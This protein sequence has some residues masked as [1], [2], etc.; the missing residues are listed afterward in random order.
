MPVTDEQLDAFLQNNPALEPVQKKAVKQSERLP[1]V[2]NNPFSLKWIP[3]VTTQELLRKDVWDDG[4]IEVARKGLN[5]AMGVN[6]LKPIS[7]FDSQRRLN[8]WWKDTGQFIPRDVLD[9]LGVQGG[10]TFEAF[11]DLE[12]VREG[13]ETDNRAR[14]SAVKDFLGIETDVSGDPLADLVTLPEVVD[15]DDFTP[16]PEVEP[17]M[18]DR[19]K[20]TDIEDLRFINETINKSPGS[21]DPSLAK[22]IDDEI[23]IKETIPE[24]MDAVADFPLLS[25]IGTDFFNSLA[26][27]L[28]EFTSRKGL[29]PTEALLGRPKGSESILIRSMARIREQ[30]VAQDPTLLA[31]IG[32][33]SGNILA[34]IIQFAALPD[35]SKAKIFAKLPKVVK[36]AIGV[37][38]KAGLIEA[39]QAPGSGDTF[40]TRAKEIVTATGIGALTGVALEVFMGSARALFK[41]IKDLPVNKQADK[42]LFNNPDTPFT[43]KEI[44]SLLKH[45]KSTDP[46]QFKTAIDFKPRKE[47]VATVRPTRPLLEKRLRPGF[48]EIEKPGKIIGKVAKQVPKT[49]EAIAIEAAKKILEVKKVAA[50]VLPPKLV[51]PE[52]A[53]PMKITFKEAEGVRGTKIVADPTLRRQLQT[54][55]NEIAQLK[56][57]RDELKA[58]KQFVK[59]TSKALEIAKKE[60]ALEALREKSAIKLEQTIEGS[61]AKISKIREAVEFKESLRNDAVSMVTA[62]PRE[63][64]A[65]FINRANK[66]KTIKALNK[67]TDE[68][69]T[70][71][72]KFERKIAVGDLRQTI[73]KIESS[74]KLG[75][76]RLAKLPSP[77]REKIMGI[78]D[79]IS[80]KK[81][82]KKPLPEGP[83]TFG[84]LDVQ[85]KRGREQ[86]LGADLESLQQVTQKLSTELAGGLEAL[87]DEAELAL[88]LPD[89]RVRRLNVL[90]QKNISE[91]DTEDIKLVTQSLQQLAQNAKL[92]TQLL[93]KKGFKPIDS[94]LKTITTQE[95]ATIG[96]ARKAAAKDRPVKVKKGKLEKVG[97]FNKK[98]LKL[99]DAHLDTLVQLS[100]NP[101]SK[102]LKQILDTDLHEGL[103]DTA[104]KT[105]EWIDLSREQFD[106]IGFKEIKQISDEVEVILAGQKIKLEK[107]FLVKLELHSRSPENLKAILKTK[108]WV[109]EGK[110]FDYPKNPDG[111]DKIN[112][113]AEIKQALNVVRGSDTLTGIADWTN[114]LTPLRADAINEVS[115]TLNGFE[116]A[117]DPFYTSRPRQLPKRVEGGKDISVPPEQQGQYLP[118]TGGTRRMRLDRWSDDFLSGIESDAFLSGMTMPLRNARV[119]VSSDSFQTAMKASGRELEL[120]NI[121]TILRR[122]QGVSTSKSTLEVFGGKLQSA[123]ATTALGFRVSTIGTQ[124]MSYPAAFADIK[125][126]MRPMTP[127]GKGTI[128][129]IEEDSALM[130]IRWQGRRIGVEV[131]T[132]ASSEAFNALFFGRTTKLSNRSMKP[133]IL[134]DKFAIGNIYKNG[135]VPEIL[136]TP[137]NGK[138]VNPFEWE[139][140]NP[141]DL[142]VLSNS[143]DKDFRYAAAR[144]LEYVVRRSQPVFDMLDRS[145]SLSNPNVLERQFFIFRTA[146]EA[147]E[148]IAIRALDGYVKSPK[149]ARDKVALSKKMG[150]VFTS[151]AAVSVWKNGLK[152][153]IRSGSTIVLAAFGIHKFDDRAER[154]D[155]PKKIAKDTVKNIV[156]LSKVGKLVVSVS[157]KVAN[158]V[159][160]DGY[161]W[162]RN[163]FDTPIIDVLESGVDA[164]VS[165]SKAV[166]DAAL[167]DEFVEE[168]TRKDVAFNEQ[169]EEQIVSDIE[170]AIRGAYDFGVRVT[171]SPFLAPAQEWLSPLMVQSKIKIIREVGFDDVDSPKDFSERVFALY[172]TRKEIQIKSKKKRLSPQEEQTLSVLDRFVKRTN[173]ASDTLKETED[174]SLRKLRFELIENNIEIVETRVRQFKE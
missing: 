46:K 10:Q 106:K 124:A 146:L 109:I 35:P 169:L 145:I 152:W 130:A 82:S 61:K 136:A 4:R 6:E 149:N 43:K 148:N 105:K 84:D 129:R 71:I 8:I 83:K 121:I 153:A 161:N 11:R 166:S 157:D 87:N 25:L 114:E 24:L 107:D 97:E 5:N 17:D 45:L 139:G 78:I 18:A 76:V 48:A 75:V 13:I 144:R 60:T 37:G 108:G 67:L 170:K 99:D 174:P 102:V 132:S 74:N 1:G 50:K 165:V 158:R 69:E 150:A 31:R 19:I 47:V 156:A 135:V 112:R 95:I 20:T 147:Q 140:E 33:E 73:K 41:T 80:L 44:V 113:L 155:L 14:A 2:I 12:R 110:S 39:L 159:S 101:G 52:E 162:N 65:A 91:I 3:D 57:R 100:T 128:S 72:D 118:R 103:R 86:L 51:S 42:I 30:V 171:G 167:L 134:G 89:E 142:P 98:L 117:R 131:G 115:L 172:E 111:T 77:Q 81:I 21:F 56:T 32:G 59:A 16:L 126:F 133:L 151:A 38:T 27:N 120:N 94:A 173:D 28:P 138:N 79:E 88:R 62:I 127:V 23:R 85:A 54:K 163:T 15:P 104:D 66:V 160:G 122:V 116:L 49:K 96:K 143:D 125:G 137:R 40:E 22:S 7:E 168:V 123:V 9:R 154:E 90:S 36:S 93:T 29:S 92:K 68:V 34:S 119:I 58:E 55:E 164:V 53:G 26:F 63:I 64:R 141:A 70:G